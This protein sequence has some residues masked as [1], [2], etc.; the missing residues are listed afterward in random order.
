MAILVV[1]LISNTAIACFSPIGGPKYDALIRIEK[2]TGS[3]HYRVEVPKRVEG[4]PL[5]AN[6][7]L[8]YST[9]HAGGIPIYEGYETIR[10]VTIGDKLVGEFTVEKKEKKS[11]MH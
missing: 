3:N 7:I 4:M 8:A 1:L 6:I 10:T 9:L 5:D 11:S 2:L